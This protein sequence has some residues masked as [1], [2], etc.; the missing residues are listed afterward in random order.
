MHNFANLRASVLVISAKIVAFF[1]LVIVCCL[2]PDNQDF[3]FS[4]FR[5]CIYISISVFLL[6]YVDFED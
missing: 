5:G 3:F 2:P 1:A 6:L 4:D